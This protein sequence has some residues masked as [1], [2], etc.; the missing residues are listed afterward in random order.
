[1]SSLT[2]IRKAAAAVLKG[3]PGTVQ[4]AVGESEDASPTRRLI[5]GVNL[6][7]PSDETRA[8]LDVLLE[9]DEAPTSVRALLAA[10]RTLGGTVSDTYVVGDSGYRLYPG[11]NGPELG[12]EF[13]LDFLD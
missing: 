6:G 11:P 8:I 10:D 4:V 13:K 1:M 2:E 12:A 3:V 7:K 5:V 9:S